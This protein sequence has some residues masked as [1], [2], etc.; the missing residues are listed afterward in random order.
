[1]NIISIITET[2]HILVDGLDAFK[3]RIMMCKSL[4]YRTHFEYHK[5]HK[6]VYFDAG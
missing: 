3:R 5:Y 2:M 6:R 1:M 4:F